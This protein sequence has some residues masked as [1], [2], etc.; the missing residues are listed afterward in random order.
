MATVLKALLYALSQSAGIDRTALFVRDIIVTQI[1]EQNINELWSIEYP[2]TVLNRICRNEGLPDAEP[3]LIGEAG[4][5]TILAC[6]RVGLY[7]NKQ[8]IGLGKRSA[9]NLIFYY[10]IILKLLQNVV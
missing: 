2:I 8:M 5:N 9:R 4:V 3:R 6:Y 10:V 1:A 7:V